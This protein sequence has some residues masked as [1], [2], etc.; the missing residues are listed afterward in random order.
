[1]GRVRG[2][3]PRSACALA[4]GATGEGRAVPE[5][6]VLVAALRAGITLALT[7]RRER[8]GRTVVPHATSAR[9]AS[10]TPRRPA[11]CAATRLW[12]PHSAIVGSEGHLRPVARAPEVS[13]R[14]T[15]R[16]SHLT[17]SHPVALPTP[18]LDATS[19]AGVT[20]RIAGSA[21]ESC[22]RPHCG[23][24][25]ICHIERCAPLAAPLGV[26][27]APLG[28]VSGQGG[29]GLPHVGH[30]T[31]CRAVRPPTLVGL[32]SDLAKTFA[33]SACDA[34]SR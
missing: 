12:P 9:S 33:K 10:A 29:V 26:S 31:Q 19:G 8:T 2:R 22:R 27:W 28:A 4:A 24:S 25:R 6:H 1:M 16:P 13:D 18:L 15:S 23:G 11:P 32:F 30:A 3:A 17:R 14:G 5:L 7:R 34:L 21:G 20:A